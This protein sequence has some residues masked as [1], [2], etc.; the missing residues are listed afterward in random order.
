[1][2]RYILAKNGYRRA[3]KGN[4][5]RA[6]NRRIK[7]GFYER[8]IVGTGID[9]GCST[10]ERSIHPSVFL[11]DK[12]IGSGDATYMKGVS[13][14]F[15]SFVY[16]SHILEHLVN[17]KTALQNWL[18]IVK[19]GGY[20]IVCVP[21]RDLFEEK[22]KLPSIYNPDHKCFFKLDTQEA[23]DTVSF[24]GLIQETFAN[25]E[26]EIIYSKICDADWPGQKNRTIE[27]KRKEMPIGEFQIE[28][29]I[30]KKNNEK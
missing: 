21:E 11:W 6:H 10:H 16:A 30:R 8:Y 12:Q 5:S 13:N 24:N 17:R 3:L 9:I 18:R 19:P 28:C 25:N 14:N 29:V 22:N 23:P 15:F 26:V 1:M 27:H 4:A 7:E 2:N 20:L